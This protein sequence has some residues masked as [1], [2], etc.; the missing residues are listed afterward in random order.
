MT[1]AQQTHSFT[2]STCE[3]YTR[4]R[5]VTTSLGSVPSPL[6]AL[7]PAHT[8]IVLSSSPHR[9][10][11]ILVEKHAS[12][13]GVCSATSVDRHVLAL[14]CGRPSRLEHRTFLGT[15]HT[16]LGR[17]D[18]VTAMPAGTVPERRVTDPTEFI[19][20]ALDVAFVDEVEGE[21]DGVSS[22]RPSFGEVLRDRSVNRIIGLLCDELQRSAKPERLY[23][24]SLGHA[25]AMRYLLAEPSA[26]A[27]RRPACSPL[28]VRILRRVCDKIEAQIDTDLSLQDLAGES[29]YSRAHFLR[30]FRAATGMTPHQYI[31]ELR[32]R[33]AK[34]YLC[35]KEMSV[36]DI[37]AVCG[38]S[39]QSHMTSAF[40]KHLSVTPAEYRRSS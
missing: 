30:M 36:I 21:L 20:C 16:C 39:S 13:A 12:P 5:A 33:K 38:F 23:A 14:I 27:A 32:L 26:S 15:W 9:W 19:Y 31:L 6:L 7:S 8:H 18:T 11:G 28:P 22:R 10:K 2:H 24:E 29:G 3:G 17:T 4:T 40:R 35:R 25:L 37:A 1:T 34:E